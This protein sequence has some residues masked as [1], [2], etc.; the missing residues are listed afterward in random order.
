MFIFRISSVLV[1]LTA[2]VT[3]LFSSAS[4]ADSLQEADLTAKTYMTALFHGDIDTASR[5][6]DA[7][8]LNQI[9]NVFLEGLEKARIES[10]VGIEDYS[11]AIA[12]SP[13]EVYVKFLESEHR[14]DP[15]FSEAMKRAIVSVSS[16]ETLGDGRAKVRMTV[17]TPKGQPGAGLFTQESVLILRAD[18]TG[19]KVTNDKQ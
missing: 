14:R 4:L 2:L 5:L 11:K 7:G 1:A 3:V 16:S 6:T 13:R 12:L 10:A 17:T 8:T 19:W 9:R 18:E 15:S